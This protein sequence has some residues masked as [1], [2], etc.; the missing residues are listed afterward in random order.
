MDRVPLRHIFPALLLYF[1]TPS[2]LSHIH[3]AKNFILKHT[4]MNAP[5]A[6]ATLAVHEEGH[7]CFEGARSYMH[8]GRHGKVTL[9]E[10]VECND[11]GLV[12]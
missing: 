12:L 4:C 2:S 5:V 8:V 7:R 1:F 10:M 11:Q 9:E 6:K 3:L